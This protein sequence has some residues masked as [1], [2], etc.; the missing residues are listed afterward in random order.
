MPLSFREEL[1]VLKKSLSGRL[2]VQNGIKHCLNE[3][4]TPKT[5]FLVLDQGQ[6][7]ETRGFFNRLG[8][9]WYKQ[10]VSKTSVFVT[11]PTLLSKP[12]VDVCNAVTKPISKSKYQY[13][14]D[15]VSFDKSK[16]GSWLCTK[17]PL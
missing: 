3:P 6:K 10:R 15:P 16:G 14:I 4:E 12:V 2:V 1:S 7:R 13:L 8:R 9:F 5:G 17:A 11:S